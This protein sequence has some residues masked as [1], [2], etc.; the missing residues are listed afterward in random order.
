MIAF[1]FLAAGSE[2]P[3]EGQVNLP[4]P[5]PCTPLARAAMPA[6]LHGA[7]QFDGFQNDMDQIMTPNYGEK[8]PP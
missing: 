4:A 7:S 2:V 3:P 1:P 5:T 6:V 8:D